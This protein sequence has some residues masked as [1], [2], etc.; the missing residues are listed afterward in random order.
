MIRH[1]TILMFVLLGVVSSEAQAD[2]TA[3]NL[4]ISGSRRV[5]Q[6]GADRGRNQDRDVY[7]G[8]D[9]IGLSLRGKDPLD[10]VVSARGIPEVDLF[11]DDPSSLPKEP[12]AAQPT[13]SLRV[14]V[15]APV[16]IGYRYC[17]PVS[18]FQ[19]AQGEVLIAAGDAEPERI[20]IDLER[21]ATFFE[22]KSGATVFSVL[23][24]GLGAIVGLISFYVQQRIS[25][26]SQEH[27]AFWQKK[28]TDEENLVAFFGDQY[29]KLRN[30][31]KPAG[32][33]A[34]ARAIRRVLSKE[35]IYAILPSSE[36]R[37]LNAICDG[38][39]WGG[40][41]VARLDRLLRRNFRE[42]MRKD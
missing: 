24:V 5:M 3:N 16:R 30:P 37:R 36:L 40:R 20:P 1:G 32:D 14:T 39:F 26:T 9:W 13:D 2:K 38:I 23:L 34:D 12:C 29:K 17:I 11:L 10:V 27:A 8:R 19:K 33:Q 35:G 31:T 22:S 42:I 25:L 4:T 7:V 41:R 15:S 21:P 6:L 18:G 28:M